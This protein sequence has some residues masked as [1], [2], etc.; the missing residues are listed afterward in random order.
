MRTIGCA[1]KVRNAHVFKPWLIVLAACLM[2]SALHAQKWPISGC[3]ST[4][5]TTGFEC[6]RAYDNSTSTL[7]KSN[8][9]GFSYIYFDLLK[10][11]SI[12]RI[13][14][15][16]TA[17]H[18]AS[19]SVYSSRDASTWTYRFPL[20]LQTGT[21]TLD[22]EWK[23]VFADRYIY[24]DFSN[25]LWELQEAEFHGPGAYDEDEILAKNIAIGFWDMRDG[26]I[27]IPPS[28]FSS[29]PMNRVVGLNTLVFDN[30][31]NAYQL[32]RISVTHSTGGTFGG[33]TR[34]EMDENGVWS[35]V[36][37]SGPYFMSRPEFS[38][39]GV[40]RGYVTVHYLSHDP[41]FP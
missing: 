33:N 27:T 15:K 30:S 31:F 11:A 40:Q 17:S 23:N 22:L 41:V 21:T 13:V 2:P 8:S 38:G 12:K 26:S 35:L 29:I 25:Q 34:F 36:V 4:P 10:S 16:S 1:Q 3:S 32:E 18:P 28:A 7:W 24:F 14:L 20:T 5:N 19:V 6:F 9:S 37:Y 39:I